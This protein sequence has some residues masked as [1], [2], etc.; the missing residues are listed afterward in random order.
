M[1]NG[2]LMGFNLE[3]KIGY[4][5]GE[6][7]RFGTEGNYFLQSCSINGFEFHP[8]IKL[9]GKNEPHQVLATFSLALNF[10]GMSGKIQ[11]E[12]RDFSG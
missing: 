5:F 6:G 7:D 9:I 11:P 10:F 12:S 2:F 4:F 3:G 1:S 8:L